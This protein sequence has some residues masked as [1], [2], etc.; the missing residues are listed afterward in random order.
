MNAMLRR[1]IPPEYAPSCSY[2]NGVLRDYKPFSSTLR[3]CWYGR[4]PLHI[5]LNIVAALPSLVEANAVWGGG[6]EPFHGPPCVSQ[7]NTKQ[8][9]KT[10]LVAVTGTPTTRTVPPRRTAAR[11]G[12]RRSLPSIFQTLPLKSR[13]TKEVLEEA[14]CTTCPPS[15]P[16]SGASH[17]ERSVAMMGR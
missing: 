9:W 4:I 16:F 1:F 12:T 17:Q 8:A 3:S 14:V 13:R 10:E 11:S 15:S 7:E 6:G 5:S 2:A